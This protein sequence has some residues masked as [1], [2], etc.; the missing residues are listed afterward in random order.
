MY[1]IQIPTSGGDPSSFFSRRID[2]KSSVNPKTP[3][4]NISGR[5]ASR[6]RR[7]VN[8]F[9]ENMSPNRN[10]KRIMVM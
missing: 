5:V 2:L 4:K 10:K 3:D 9:A 6:S 7:K 8:A 1:N